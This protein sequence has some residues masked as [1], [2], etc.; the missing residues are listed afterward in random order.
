M[1]ERT[2]KLFPGLPM[3][4]LFAAILPAAIAFSIWSAVGQKHFWPFGVA[5]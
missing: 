2:I 5:T 4:A 1:N 3:I